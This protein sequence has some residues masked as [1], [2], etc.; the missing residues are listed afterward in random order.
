MKNTILCAKDG[1]FED[2]KIFYFRGIA[3]IVSIVPIASMVFLSATV[4]EG[5][6]FA[7]IASFASFASI[8][9]C[10]GALGSPAI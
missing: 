9:N 4:R 10:G 2:V 8:K 3:S 6:A 1:F 7:S 5:F